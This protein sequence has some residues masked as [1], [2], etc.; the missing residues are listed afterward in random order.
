MNYIVASVIYVTVADMG[1]YDTPCGGEVRHG[2]TSGVPRETCTQ[3]G[4]G[5][6]VRHGVTSGVS[7]ETSKQC[8]LCVYIHMYVYI[9]TYIYI[10]IHI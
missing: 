6:E 2:V 9:Y 8:S 3:N 5:C 7:R 10:Y 1:S 4:I